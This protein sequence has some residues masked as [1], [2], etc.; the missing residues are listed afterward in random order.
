MEKNI[1]SF[2]VF[3]KSD[4]SY[5]LCMTAEAYCEEQAKAAMSKSFSESMVICPVR[6]EESRLDIMLNAFNSMG[7]NSDDSK[8]FR[9][10]R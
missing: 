6:E 1:Y 2:R 4:D 10:S 7:V 9:V 8:N 3:D 5:F